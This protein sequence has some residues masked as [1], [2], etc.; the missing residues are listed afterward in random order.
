IRQDTEPAVSGRSA[1]QVQQLI[2]AI[3]ASSNSGAAVSLPP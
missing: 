1:L 3:M 2:A